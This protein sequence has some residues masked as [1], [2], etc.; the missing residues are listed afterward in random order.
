MFNFDFPFRRQG[1]A[2]IWPMPSGPN[3]GFTE[4]AAILGIADE[5]P[6][7]KKSAPFGMGQRSSLAG[8]GTSINY[9]DKRLMDEPTEAG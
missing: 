2:T 3:G 8:L 1:D 7:G 9:G 4:T 5:T 6:H